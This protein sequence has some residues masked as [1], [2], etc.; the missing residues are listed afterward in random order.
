MAVDLT[1]I[2]FLS[3]RENGLMASSR[4]SQQER[5]VEGSSACDQD[6]CRPGI[7]GLAYEP[8]NYRRRQRNYQTPRGGDESQD[9]QRRGEIHIAGQVSAPHRLQI[10]S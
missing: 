3:A 4:E 10:L 2:F 7:A 5:E 9:S 6:H 8:K 1:K